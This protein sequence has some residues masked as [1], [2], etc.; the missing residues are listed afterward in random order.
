MTLEINVWINL[1][2]KMIHWFRTA[3]FHRFEIR[4]ITWIH[5]CL[6]TQDL[7]QL[8]T[9]QQLSTSRQPSLHPIT[10]NQKLYHLLARLLFRNN[11]SIKIEIN[12]VQISPFTMTLNQLKQNTQ[13]QQISDLREVNYLLLSSSLIIDIKAR[14]TIMSMDLNRTINLC[15]GKSSLMKNTD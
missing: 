12:I 2:W 4:P 7:E 3:P 11:L 8:E 14:T 1:T 15:R 9:K 5:W 6:R 13:E 10:I